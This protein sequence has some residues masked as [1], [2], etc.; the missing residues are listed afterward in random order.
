M[1]YTNKAQLIGMKFT[2]LGDEHK[3]VYTFYDC[4]KSDRI[5][6]KWGEAY[7]TSYIL[8]D[9]L[10]YLNKGEWKPIENIYQIY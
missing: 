4:V 3:I 2:C 5:G 9:V 7:D 6:I 1:T 10:D 8:G